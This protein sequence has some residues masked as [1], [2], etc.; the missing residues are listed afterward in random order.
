MQLFG[1]ISQGKA[2]CLVY[3][4]S[5]F[6]PQPH[7]W[8]PE[9]WKEWLLSKIRNRL[10]TSPQPPPHSIPFFTNLILP[11]QHLLSLL[12]PDIFPFVPAKA[13]FT[14]CTHFG[15]KGN[16]LHIC[17]R[18]GLLLVL[19]CC[20]AGEVRNMDRE[21]KV[22]Y[23]FVQLQS[24]SP[25]RPPFCGSSSRLQ[26]LTGVY[27]LIG[28]G[29]TRSGQY[30]FT[31]LWWSLCVHTS[32]LMLR[33]PGSKV[34]RPSHGNWWVATLSHPQYHVWSPEHPSSDT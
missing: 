4:Q 21:R 25:H 3:Q 22:L 19:G 8:S 20:L 30:I 24:V 18:C 11:L 2:N 7:R 32:V 13:T 31:L 16:H 15:E 9:H 10:W 34:T 5:C 26:Y 28:G 12:F 1:E 14:H 17:M 23:W 27:L 33:V 6:D 29:G